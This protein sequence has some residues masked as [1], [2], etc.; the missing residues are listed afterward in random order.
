MILELLI[1]FVLG[2]VFGPY[3]YSK[4]YRAQSPFYKVSSNGN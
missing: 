3:L 2:F 4:G 1:P